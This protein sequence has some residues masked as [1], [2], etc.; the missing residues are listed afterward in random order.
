MPT[1]RVC[2]AESLRAAQ[3]IIEKIPDAELGETLK[4]YLRENNHD[5]WDLF[6]PA[7]RHGIRTLFEDLILYSDGR[8]K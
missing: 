6:S 7:Q 8:R 4:L 3:D 2:N 1:R 5:S